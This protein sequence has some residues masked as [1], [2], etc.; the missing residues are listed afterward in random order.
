MVERLDEALG[1]LNDTDIDVGLYGEAHLRIG[2]LE[3][4]RQSRKTV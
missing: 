1:D 2:G 3:V 4:P